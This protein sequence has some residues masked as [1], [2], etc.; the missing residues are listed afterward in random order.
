MPSPRSGDVPKACRSMAVALWWTERLVSLRQIVTQRHSPDPPARAAV[1]PSFRGVRPS[2]DPQR[3]RRRTLQALGYALQYAQARLTRSP[4]RPARSTR[5]RASRDS[6]SSRSPRRSHSGRQPVC[7]PT[8][9]PTGDDCVIEC[10]ARIEA[11][12]TLASPF[13]SVRFA[14]GLGAL[15]AAACAAACQSTP[16]A[17]A[18][19]VSADTWA[20]VDGRRIMRDD[21]EKA[22]RRSGQAAEALSDEEAMTAKLSLLN[23]LIA[24]VPPAGQSPRPQSGT[25]GERARGR[26]RRGQ[27]EHYR[28]GVSTGAQAARRDG[29]RHAEGLRR[30]LLAQKAIDQEVISKIG[31]TDAEVTDYFNANRAQFNYPEEGY[32]SRRSW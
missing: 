12:S 4:D 8:R 20:T 1:G 31:V 10:P 30:E 22:F 26:L 14:I 11:G 6:S 21:V 29:G 7:W 3:A 17:Q 9:P 16:V 25:S 32:A 23:E 24:Q 18:P 28:R 27:K 15:A 13:R 5:E 19:S 2:P